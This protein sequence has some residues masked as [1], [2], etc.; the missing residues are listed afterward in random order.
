MRLPLRSLVTTI[1][2]SLPMASVM[3]PWSVAISLP[4]CTLKLSRVRVAANSN[5]K[6]A[7]SPAN[8]SVTSEIPPFN[9]P[10]RLSHWSA[11]TVRLSPGLGVSLLGFWMFADIAI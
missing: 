6:L 3:P 11:V 8:L 2:S 7:G 1:P 4:S 9:T 10:S 5:G